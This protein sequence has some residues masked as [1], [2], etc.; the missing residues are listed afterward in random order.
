MAVAGIDIGSLTADVVI[1]RDGEIISDVIIPTGSNSR[2]AADR[3]LEAALE[4]ASLKMEDLDYIVA[5]G[6]GRANVSRAHKCVTEITCHGRG[7]HYLD[8]SVRTVIDIGGQDSKVIR[9]NERGE[10]QDFAMNDKCAA[11]TGRFL[12]VMAHALEVDLSEMA[13]IS[14][15][16]SR[17]APIS[18]MCTVFAESEVVSLIAQGVPREEIISGLHEAIAGRTAG[19][20]FRVGLEKEV[21]MTGGVAKNRGVVKSLEKKLQCKIIVPPEPQI[22]GALGAALLAREEL[23]RSR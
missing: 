21:M 8:P 2:A 7:A 22:I 16:A 9:L 14:E 10:V 12:E 20:V 13:S 3:A 18:S 11:G 4:Q 23:E 1:L 6:Y 15:R 17:S 19:M 5:T